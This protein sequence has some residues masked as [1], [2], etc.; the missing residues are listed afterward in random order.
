[1]QLSQVFNQKAWPRAGDVDDCWVVS[2]IQCTNTV[3]PWLHLPDVTQFRAA[4]GDPDDGVSDGGNSAEIVKGSVG[5]WPVLTGR[6]RA[7]RLSWEAFVAYVNAGHPASIALMTGKLPAGLNHGQA[8]NIAHQCSVARPKQGSGEPLYFANPLAPVY[9]HWDE[10]GYVDIK[11]AVL[12]YGNGAVVGVGWPT[13]AEAYRLHP[14]W[15]P[16]TEAATKAAVT[17]ATATV[18]AANTALTAK[19]TALEK[20][21]AD[22]RITCSSAVG[23]AQAAVTAEQ[24]FIAKFSG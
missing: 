4:A 23:A 8:T 19:N 12:D 15:T 9:S 3:F 22:L 14:L 16:Q 17:A 7:F 18:T 11:A 2:A 5:V 10:C 1:M 20:T 6:L 21:L 24:A 13:E